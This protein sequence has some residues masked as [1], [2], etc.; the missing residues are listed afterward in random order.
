ME[1]AYEC[2]AGRPGGQCRTDCSCPCHRPIGLSGLPAARIIGAIL[3]ARDDMEDLDELRRLV[4]VLLVR[5]SDHRIGYDQAE[6]AGV[7]TQVEAMSANDRMVHYHER[8]DDDGQFQSAEYV[9]GPASLCDG[10]RDAHTDPV[11]SSAQSL[12]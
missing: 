12:S 11:R 5:S 2:W 4:L 10:T 7:I 6:Y 8:Y 3:Q 1:H 9:F